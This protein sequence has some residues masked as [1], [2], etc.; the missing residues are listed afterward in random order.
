MIP[1]SRKNRFL[2]AK[3]NGLSL[4]YLPLGELTGREGFFGVAEKTECETVCKARLKIERGA[5]RHGKTGRRRRR[6]WVL[7]QAI[8]PHS[9]QVK[10]ASHGRSLSTTDSPNQTLMQILFITKRNS[11]P[12][13]FCWRSS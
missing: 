5:E 3:G 13:G 10:Y 8:T 4:A 12:G 7:N 11:S 1:F 2:L 9:K 6:Q